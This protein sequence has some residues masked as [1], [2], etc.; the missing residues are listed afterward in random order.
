MAGGGFPQI[1][2]CG[3]VLLS[4]TV[5]HAVPSALEGLTTVFEM[6]TGVA[7]PLSPPQSLSSSAQECGRYVFSCVPLH[8]VESN[9]DLVQQ[10]RHVQVLEKLHS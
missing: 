5:T 10:W 2:K 4:H 1:V 3:S 9:P 8:S 7:P 6:G